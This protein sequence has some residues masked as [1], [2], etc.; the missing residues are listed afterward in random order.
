MFPTKAPSGGTAPLR[1]AEQYTGNER[2][3]SSRSRK[4]NAIIRDYSMTWTTSANLR[5]H[6][7]PG[8]TRF[9]KRRAA[10]MAAERVG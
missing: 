9:G 4:R 3:V 1:A 7:S 10:R 2:V 5:T 6:G 8:L